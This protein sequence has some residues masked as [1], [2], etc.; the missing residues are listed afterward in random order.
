M[1]EHLHRHSL[2]A[3]AIFLAGCGS[4]GGLGGSVSLQQEWQIGD[5]MAAQI[6][7]QVRLSNDQQVVSYV[8]QVGERI[9]AVTN[10]ANLPYQ[11]HVVEDRSV[12]AFSILG[13]H[14]YVNT[15]LIANADNA[16]MLAGVMAHEIAHVTQRHVI[17]QV[18]KEQTIN[19]I[20]SILLGQNQNALAAIVAQVVA[21][22]AMAKFSRS[23]EHEADEV[24]LKLLTAAGYDGRG[25]TEMFQ[26]LVS[27]EKS[28]PSA[29]EQFF[30]SH[31]LTQDRINDMNKH[32]GNAPA[33]GIVDDPAYQSVRRR[34]GG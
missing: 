23:D 29:V 33:R 22:G 21:G 18:Q 16:S 3:V 25:M 11:F 4:G 20:G 19:T 10:Q 13:G 15:G 14:V 32:I 26:K 7:Q 30:A 2:I 12:N 34:V 6:A 24:G 17:K 31:P 28:R 5:Q 1:K 8:R 27:L 9:H